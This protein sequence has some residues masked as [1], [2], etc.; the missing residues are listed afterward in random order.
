MS[1][2]LNYIL[3]HEDA[4][5]KYET[6]FIDVMEQELNQEGTNKLTCLISKRPETVSPPSTP[7]SRCKERRTPTA[8]R[9]M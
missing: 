6:T 9:S 8:T 7:I 3:S 4:F 5:R 2:L 1:E